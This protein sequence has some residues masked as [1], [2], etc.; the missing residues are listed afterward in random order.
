MAAEM[1][2]VMQADVGTLL[3]TLSTAIVVTGASDGMVSLNLSA[4]DLL[5]TSAMAARG[6][7]FA[8]LLA[9]GEEVDELIVR[10]RSG[11]EALVRRECEL[12]PLSRVGARYLVDCTVT[13]IAQ[14]AV[15][16]MNDMTRQ[17]RLTRETAL[18]A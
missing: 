6:K 18:L 9:G 8:D 1:R 2:A 7:R 14:G 5:A 3:D 10:A 12:V 15:V 11:G 16:E 17:S 4:E 13:P